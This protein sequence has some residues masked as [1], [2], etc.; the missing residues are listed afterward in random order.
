MSTTSTPVPS[1]AR[2]CRHPRPTTSPT[3]STP[4]E[5]RCAQRCCNHSP[6]RHP[7]VRLDGRRTGDVG[8]GRSGHS[9]TPTR[10]TTRCGRSGGAL[11]HGGRLV[12]VPPSV[13]ASP[14]EFHALLV[15]E[16]V[17]VLSQ[18]PPTALTALSPDGLE[19]AALM[20]A[21]EA[22]PAEVVDRWASGGRVMINGYGPTETTVYATIS[23]PMSPGGR[24]CRSVRRCLEPRCSCWTVGCVRCRGGVV[25]ELYVAGG[26]CRLRLCEPARAHRITVHRL[27]PLRC[28]RHPDVPHRRSRQV[29]RRWAAAVS[30]P[31]R[32]AGQDPRISH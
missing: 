4:R 13:A 24:A 10:S 15:R 20:V 21:G 7:P 22:C 28:T 31:R 1:P 14:V 6:Q 11:L 18:T 5:H 8:G 19:S 16:Q 29:G 26:G 17:T 25:G 9:A 27:P 23:R 3:S 32:R 12:V 2:P 30:G